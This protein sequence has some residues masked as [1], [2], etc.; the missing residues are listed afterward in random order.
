MFA[1]ISVGAQAVASGTFYESWKAY[2]Y[3]YIKNEM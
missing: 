1:S 2:P 3:C